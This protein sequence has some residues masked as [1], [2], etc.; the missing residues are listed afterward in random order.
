MARD[1]FAAALR[2]ARLRA[3]LTQAA[4]AEQAGI[5]TRTIQHLEAGRG[6]PYA[7]TSTRLADALG[8]S[9]ES[10]GVLGRVGMW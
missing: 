8:L 2:E 5:S 6:W 10:R 7:A 1:T 3:D 4:L 9:S